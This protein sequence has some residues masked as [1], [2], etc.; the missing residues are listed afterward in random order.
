MASPGM[1]YVGVSNDTV[2]DSGGWGITI[3]AGTWATLPDGHVA[4]T[5]VSVQ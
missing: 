4:L 5:R 2:V 3:N 1:L